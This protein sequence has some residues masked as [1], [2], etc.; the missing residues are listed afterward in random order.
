[1]AWSRALL[2]ATW[3]VKYAAKRRLKSAEPVWRWAVSRLYC[4]GKSSSSSSYISSLTT[5][6]S[7][8]RNERPVRRLWISDA[9]RADSTRASRL[10]SLRRD[11]AM[12]ALNFDQLL[13]NN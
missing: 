4:M 12:Y 13:G 7:V 11:A 5:S 10:R 2:I 9:R 1:M 6:C 8:T 3:F